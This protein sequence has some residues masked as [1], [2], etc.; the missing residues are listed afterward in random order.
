MKTI[1]AVDLNNVVMFKQDVKAYLFK[2]SQ[3]VKI[4]F[5]VSDYMVVN[6]HIS[7][8]D[9]EHILQHWRT[10]VHGLETGSGRVWWYHKDR[11]PRPHCIPADYVSIDFLH[12][13][14]RIS[15]HT[16]LQLQDSYNYQKN[17]H[18]HWDT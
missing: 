15:V 14:F 17:N 18:I 11:G 4:S 5:R 10:G 9:M 8:E 1:S 3:A 13:N 7:Q 6:L 2:E 16:M 12:Y